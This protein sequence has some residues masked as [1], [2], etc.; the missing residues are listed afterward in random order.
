MRGIKVF[1]PSSSISPKKGL[2]ILYVSVEGGG[3]G[4]GGGGLIWYKR[5][6]HRSSPYTNTTLCSGVLGKKNVVDKENTQLAH[7]LAPNYVLSYKVHPVSLIGQ[8]FTPD[9]KLINYFMFLSLLFLNIVNQQTT[10][11]VL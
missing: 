9:N 8:E 5:C 6:L 1:L 2:G 7:F 3:R 11:S 10:P 4:E